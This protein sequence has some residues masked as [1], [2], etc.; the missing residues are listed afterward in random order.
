[1]IIFKEV[2]SESDL[3]LVEKMAHDIWHEHYTP[4]IGQDQVIYMLNKYQSVSSMQDQIDSGYRYFLI[5]AKEQPVGYLSYE[6]RGRSLF[7]SKIYLLKEER[8]KG[9]GRSSMEFVANTARGLE[10]DKV[11]LTV[12]RFNKKSIQ[13]YE[14]AGFEKKGELVQD[15]GN[16]FVMDDYAMEKS[17]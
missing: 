5:Y 16:G 6:L 3:I 12:N 8:G 13:A 2:K 7:L 1:M 10:C 17:L 4:I 11:S 14:S 15:I 9:I